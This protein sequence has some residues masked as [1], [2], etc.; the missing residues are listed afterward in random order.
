M[1]LKGVPLIAIV[2]PTCTGKTWLSLRLAE[3]LSTEIIACDSRTIYRYMDIG[4]AKP[5]PDERAQIRHH[6]LDLVDPD[7]AYSVARYKEDAEPIIENLIENSKPPIVCGGTGFYFRNLLEGLSIPAVAPQIELR[8]SLNEIGDTQGNAVLHAKLKALDP[9]SA[10]RIN[11]NDRFR[12]VRALEVSIVCGEPFSQLAKRHEP[13][14]K[15]VW[16]GLYSEDRSYLDELIRRRLA[17]QSELGL[18]AEV[19]SLVSR[20]GHCHSLLHTVSYKEHVQYLDNEIDLP[21][22]ALLSAR[23]TYQLARRQ[24]MWFRSNEK[25]R[26]FAI[27]RIDREQIFLDVILMVREAIAQKAQ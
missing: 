6:M 4:T 3:A 16:V 2:G 18:L 11:A 25:I 7:Q 5:T 23:H 20:F 19:E 9:T 12:V 22:A 1:N 8:Q 26:W 10:D 24:L 27:D 15:V 14:Y 17:A 21:E 13:T